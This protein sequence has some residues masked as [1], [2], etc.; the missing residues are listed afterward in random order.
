M[1]IAAASTCASCQAASCKYTCP[2]CAATTCSLR[3][4]QEHRAT[5]A[6]EQARAA[7]EAE[8]AKGVGPSLLARERGNVARFVPMK[9]Y[10]YNQMLDDYQFLNKVGRMVSSTGR[11]LSEAHMLPQDHAPGSHVRRGTASQQRREALAKQLGFHKLPIMLLPDGMSRRKMNRTHWGAK[12]RCMF[13]TLQVQFPCHATES[14]SDLGHLV[15]GP[16]IHSLSPSTVVSTEVLSD[17]ERQCARRH[18]MSLSQWHA[19]TE[20]AEHQAKRHKRDDNQRF[21]RMDPAILGLLGLTGTDE[22]WT[23][24]PT[25]AR[26]LLHIYELRLRNETSAKYLD[27]WLR[28]GASQEP[29]ISLVRPPPAV[30]LPQ[31]VLDHVSQ[32]CSDT[33]PVN[34]PAA[35]PN[36]V[37]HYVEV[38]AAMT[39]DALLRS[40]P[41]NFGIVEFPEVSIWPTQ[42]LN[43][44]QRR[45]Q[46]QLHSLQEEPVK[47]DL[48]KDNVPT[49]APSPLVAAEPQPIPPKQAPVT[50]V[51]YADS[52]DDDE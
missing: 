51:A 31:H 26:L 49:K 27:W 19:G 1:P 39:L 15:Q 45:G 24:W 36:T 23:Q 40:L 28:K 30:L 48:P 50:L 10:D 25:S 43:V 6:C 52:S 8:R 37:Q 22:V 18:Q 17:L 7:F 16:L 47:Q 12:Q 46:V 41:V 5:K 14:V 32:L 9:D 34:S 44:A 2:Y 38:P 3:C 13:Y 33:P 29:P 11:S 4:S 21:W 35:L 42:A 20:A